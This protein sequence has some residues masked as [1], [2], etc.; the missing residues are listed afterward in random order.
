VRGLFSVVGGKL[1]TYRA[2]AQEAVELIFR[3]LGKTPPPCRTADAPLPGAAV[4][5]LEGFRRDFNTRSTLPP[6]S[7]ARLLK[8]YGARA[9]QVLRLAQSDAELSRVIS[10]ETGSIGAEV[11]HA[12]REELAET[13]ADC[14]MR[15][16]M[17]G[18]NGSVGLDA[19]E[20][21]AHVAQKFL[22]W[23]DGRVASEVEDYRSYAGR[24]H[25]GRSHG[26]T[27]RRVV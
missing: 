16:T 9:T 14:L 13:L 2:L 25:P 21:A 26:V 4:E 27:A 10:E 12:F 20:K 18:L 5:D 19:V 24:F 3:A 1:T 7:T 8:V 6:S 15:R 17:V 23:D 11:V 22:G